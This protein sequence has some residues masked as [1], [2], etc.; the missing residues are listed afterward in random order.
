GAAA[1]WAAGA[2]CAVAAGLGTELREMGRGLGRG[3]L[4]LAQASKGKAVSPTASARLVASAVDRSAAA[5]AG[6]VTAFLCGGESFNRS[7]LRSILMEYV[8]KILKR[9]GRSCLRHHRGKIAAIG[10]LGKPDAGQPKKA[11]RNKALAAHG[12]A[13][14]PDR[15]TR[16]ELKSSFG[17]AV[18]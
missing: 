11:R 1:A 5:R 12:T 2:V 16:Y 10:T 8:D 6:M 14:S 9:R 18:S 4:G 17:R 13:L 15:Q 3:T 7:S